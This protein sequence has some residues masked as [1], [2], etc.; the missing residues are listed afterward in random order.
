MKNENPGRRS[1]SQAPLAAREY[2]L[3]QRPKKSQNP[4]TPRR[5]QEITKRDLFNGEEEEND[6]LTRKTAI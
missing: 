4:K 5:I 6:R 2:E 3:S 1:V